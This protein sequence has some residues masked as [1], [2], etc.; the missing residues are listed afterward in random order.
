MSHTHTNLNLALQYGH[1]AELWT[2]L[3]LYWQATLTL[4]GGTAPFNVANW[5][6][7]LLVTL[8][9][10]IYET[11]RG[12]E[13]HRNGSFLWLRF[14]SAWFFSLQLLE[15]AIPRTADKAR[16]L[17]FQ[18]QNRVTYNNESPLRQNRWNNRQCLFENGALLITR[19]VK[20]KSFA[21][22]G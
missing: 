9:F 2:M 17:Y 12:C 13:E 20:W 1:Y 16:Q 19:N 10:Y 4:G 8:D 7:H 18:P 15:N 14:L 3:E 6:D 11:G 21:Y 5:I 22:P